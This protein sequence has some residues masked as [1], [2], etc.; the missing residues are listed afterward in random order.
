MY[1]KSNKETYGQ[2]RKPRW[3]T[4]AHIDYT[5]FSKALRKRKFNKALITP[6]R[7]S[8]DTSSNYYTAR[9]FLES[10]NG[11]NVDG[12]TIRQL[13]PNYKWYALTPSGAS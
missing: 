11:R 6:R 2:N 7:F 8:A 4:S 13:S 5:K 9:S 3:V 1:R 12:V 10:A